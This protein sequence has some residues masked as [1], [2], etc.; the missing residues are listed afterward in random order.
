MMLLMYAFL[1]EVEISS[2]NAQRLSNF[3]FLNILAIYW[4]YHKLHGTRELLCKSSF[5][6]G[7]FKNQNWS[8]L[9]MM[10]LKIIRAGL[11][12]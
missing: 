12:L 3:A 1:K 10:S 11:R 2:L 5:E 7:V 4:Q 9:Y 6:Y 8:A